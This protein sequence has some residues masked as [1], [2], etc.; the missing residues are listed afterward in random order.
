MGTVPVF[1]KKGTVMKTWIASLACV[2][3]GVAN[4]A[5]PARLKVALT[6]DDL[7]LNGTQPAGISQSQMA[8][9]TLAVLKKYTVPPSYGFINALG[10]ENNPDG[11]LMLQL[12]VQ[13]GYP[14]GNHTYTHL[15]L[16]KNSAAD[17]TREI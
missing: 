7:P 11:A 15:N 13:A 8:R 2:V 10:L 16:D 12:W 3:L 17:F 4:A 1:W 6:F 5:E 9:D 14:L